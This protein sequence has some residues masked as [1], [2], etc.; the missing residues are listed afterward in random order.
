[1]K[2]YALK[3]PELS[4]ANA[5]HSAFERWLIHRIEQLSGRDYF[6]PLYET[7]RNEVIGKS[8]TIIFD[9]LNLLEVKLNLHCQ[10]EGWPFKIAPEEPLV[11]VA[12]HPFGIGDGIAI[13]ALAEQLKRPFKILINQDLLKVP[14]M[15]PYSIPIDFSEGRE[16]METNMRSRKETL[17]LLKQGTTIIIFPAGGVAT[18]KNPF[19]KAEELP[20]KN[21][22]ARLIRSAQASVL[23]I[24]FEGQNSFFFHLVSQFSM[25]LRISLLIAEFRK[26]AGSEVNV[27]IGDIIPFE[28][29]EY[30]H[31]RKA[32]TKELFDLVHNLAP[33]KQVGQLQK[34]TG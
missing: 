33:K 31:D 18:A 11:I 7:W 20:W 23:P 9:M 22:T 14:E 16:A 3:F 32:L 30:N 17:E 28:G 5:G 6:V 19:G 8:D 13:L 26:F 25:T 10:K 21:F 29:L 27:H 4:Y 12:N 15:K 24:Y 1:M 2:D 34:V